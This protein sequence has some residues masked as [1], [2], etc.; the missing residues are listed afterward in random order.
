MT[1]SESAICGEISTKP[2]QKQETEPKLKRKE[3]APEAE[4]ELN[5]ENKDKSIN[6]NQKLNRTKK[7][8][9]NQEQISRTKWDPG[10][11]KFQKEENNNKR[12]RNRKKNNN[13]RNSNNLYSMGTNTHSSND[14]V[15]HRTNQKKEN[16]E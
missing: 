6:K 10:K 4:P 8:I 1:R 7:V 15:D 2:I 9:M 11:N 14:V 13:N 5:K 3:Q 12:R 16:K